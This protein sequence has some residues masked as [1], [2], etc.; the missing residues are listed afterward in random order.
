ME[1]FA[2]LLHVLH[3]T[4][5]CPISTY[6]PFRSHPSGTKHEGWWAVYVLGTDITGRLA[7][8]ICVRGGPGKSRSNK[9]YPYSQGACDNIHE[10]EKILLWSKHLSPSVPTSAYQWLARMLSQEGFWNYTKDQWKREPLLIA[11]PAASPGWEKAVLF[12]EHLTSL[13]WIVKC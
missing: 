5:P 1:R 12:L 8:H 2:F 7:S 9:P 11:S 3:C 10:S 6:P 13:H 4:S